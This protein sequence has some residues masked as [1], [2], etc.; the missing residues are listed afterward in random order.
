MRALF[1]II[2]TVMVAAIAGGAG[3]AL[4]S[5]GHN[6]THSHGAPAQVVSVAGCAGL[7]C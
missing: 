1:W 7:A 4:I 5:A 3:A 6:G 2:G